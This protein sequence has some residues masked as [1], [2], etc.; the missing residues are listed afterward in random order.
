MKENKTIRIDNKAE[1]IGFIR[2]IGNEC[3]FVTVNTETEV[4]MPKGK[5]TGRK[6]P[7]PK[8]G[9][10]INE[11]TPNP[12]HG[13]IK[14]ARRNGFVNANFVTA[15]EKRFAELSGIPQSDVT[16]T[17]GETWYIHCHAEDGSP[18]CLCEHKTEPERKYMQFFPL[19][20]LGET[21]YI[22][23]TLGKL[24]EAQVKDMYANWV[25]EDENPEW[26]PR[27]IVLDMD[28]IRMI[29]FRKVNMLNDT[30]SRI[31]ETMSKWKQ[32]KVSTRPPR[33]VRTEA[34]IEAFHTGG[35]PGW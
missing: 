19:R 18:L 26:K 31:A 12:Y 15:V 22:H 21:T 6:V 11:K 30:F 9:K 28:S 4:S 14:V 24:T 29:T 25:P 34:E 33:A 27:V 8:T 16:Y 23:P 20:N 13:T 7:S 5:P 1:L 17:P 32:T 35:R 2:S 10:P 3:R